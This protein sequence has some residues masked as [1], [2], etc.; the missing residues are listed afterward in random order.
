[1]LVL[2]INYYLAKDSTFQEWLGQVSARKELP[3]FPSPGQKRMDPL[4]LVTMVI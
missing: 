4:D 2:D 3:P 1:M